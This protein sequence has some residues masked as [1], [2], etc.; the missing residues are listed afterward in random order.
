M[1]FMF[2]PAKL[3]MNCARARGASTPPTALEDG[4]AV[5]A[6]TIACLP[7]VDETR[8]SACTPRGGIPWPLAPEPVTRGIVMIAEAGE[9]RRRHF[10]RCP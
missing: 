8:S 1:T 9:S 7:S 3:Q 6:S 10:T 5:T 2:D 4:G